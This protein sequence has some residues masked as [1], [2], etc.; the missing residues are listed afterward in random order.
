VAGRDEDFSAYVRGR[1]THLVRIAYLLCGDKAQ[2]EDV[3]QSALAK[4]Y[5]AWPRIR[6]TGALDAYVR[7]AIVN[8]TTSWWRRA[9]R[10]ERPVA[11][12]PDQP[13]P[14]DP[15]EQT[16]DRSELVPALRALP[17]G[18]RAV[19]VLRYFEDL[20]EEQTAAALGVSVGTVKSQ[21]ARGLA[22]LRRSLVRAERTD[23]G[24]GR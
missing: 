12:L 20:S 1:Y 18:Q 3:T 10:R 22:T 15:G 8:E 19:M 9:A 21:H 17:P 5:R 6:D 4:T 2:A 16:A 11:D 14:G 24:G 13:A 23:V 7:R